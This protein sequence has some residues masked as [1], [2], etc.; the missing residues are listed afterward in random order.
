MANVPSDLKYVASHEWVRIEADG[1]VT[2]GITDFAQ[3]ALGDVV[4]VEL[5]EV[6][7]EFDADAEC[8]V[9]ESVK[10][11][12]DIYAP[13]AGKIIAVNEDLVDAPEKANE[14]PYGEAWFFKMELA[15]AADLDGLMDAAAYTAACES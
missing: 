3:E 12:S 2:I 5:P 13:L 7:A 11:A 9:V 14:D 15:N 1:T 4:F 8:A 10:A 6:D